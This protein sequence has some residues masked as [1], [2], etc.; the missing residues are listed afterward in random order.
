MFHVSDG[1]NLDLLLG[2]VAATTE[3]QSG[4]LTAVANLN[5]RS[6]ATNI[7]LVFLTGCGTLAQTPPQSPNFPQS[8]PADLGQPV[9]LN[10]VNVPT[11]RQARPEDRHDLPV[12][13][14]PRQPP[15]QTWVQARP[16]RPALEPTL[17]LGKKDQGTFLASIGRTRAANQWTRRDQIT[18]RRSEASP[19]PQSVS[20]PSFFGP[21]RTPRAN[22]TSRHE[23]YPTKTRE[24]PRLSSQL[25]S[26]RSAQ[27]LQS[28]D[29]PAVGHLSQMPANI[30]GHEANEAW[31]SRLI[32][33]ALSAYTSQVPTQPTS[34][35]P[36]FTHQTSTQPM[37]PQP[38]FRCSSYSTFQGS[39]QPTSQ[40]SS[41]SQS[42]SQRSSLSQSMTQRS[43]LSEHETLWDSS[44]LISSPQQPPRPPGLPRPAPGV[45]R[46]DNPSSPV[47]QNSASGPVNPL[48]DPR[49]LS[50]TPSQSNHG[51]DSVQPY[52]ASSRSRT[53]NSPP[54]A[55]ARA[56]SRA[57]QQE[58]S[59]LQPMQA[60]AADNDKVGDIRENEPCPDPSAKDDVD[61][62]AEHSLQI[63][64]TPTLF[65]ETT[66]S[67]PT[68]LPNSG[69]E[70]QTS[71]ASA[72]VEPY[73]DSV[74]ESSVSKAPSDGSPPS[75]QEIPQ[76]GSE[77]ETA[78]AGVTQSP[79][80]VGLLTT[81]GL[82][83][84]PAA[85]DAGDSLA[86]I[87]MDQYT[88]S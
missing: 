60:D 81:L 55:Q 57:A 7:L 76:A 39:S 65:S 82:A 26:R 5:H 27:S 21:S 23:P 85:P 20:V 19:I 67:A 9:G 22:A 35:Q 44:R 41:L 29:G 51:N 54:V 16:Q 72:L 59:L 75:T 15:T 36:M 53:R 38:P 12:P 70:T 86:K 79:P 34:A 88:T 80:R 63:S 4:Y 87:L 83:D 3:L 40:R 45:H 43:S 30:S 77:H 8:Q 18:A 66:T 47:S 10:H 84:G 17:E 46:Q 33:P 48:Y 49:W 73:A 25:E 32:P 14:P 52:P 56:R 61:K 68:F 28:S 11:R 6:A 42:T 50:R 24:A 37:P 31:W 58:T 13:L 74:H 69:E 71:S 62:S 64:S 2:A 78:P 1:Y